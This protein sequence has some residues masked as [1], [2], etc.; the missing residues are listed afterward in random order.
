MKILLIGGTG[1][2]SSSVTR[3]AIDNGMDVTLLNRGNRPCPEGAHS[4]IADMNDE[5]T[6]KQ[7]LSGQHFDVVANFIVFTPEQAQRDIRLFSGITDK[8]IF[9]SS[10][11]AYQK[12]PLSPFITEDTPLENP[13]WEYSRNKAACEQ[14]YLN[15]Y[16]KNGFPAVI[17]RPSHT[18]CEKNV[19]VAIHGKGGSYTVLKRMLDGKKVIVHGDGSSLWTLTHSRDFAK[20][21]VGLME[22]PNVLGQAFHITSD[23]SLCWNRIYQIVADCLGVEYRPCHITSDDLCK[24]DPEYI[25]TLLGDKANSVIF[26]NTKIKSVAPEFKDFL[27]FAQGA[28]QAV[29]YMLSHPEC[30]FVD[31]EFNA[32]CDQMIALS[33]KN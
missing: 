6:V 5:N 21:F 26:D 24:V 11:S 31:E 10:A 20:G 27:P 16:D 23:E 12:P 30:Q 29:D 25:G 19:P 4:L 33:E 13:F 15:E 9:I 18:Y 17:V 22:A 32:F 2:I 14:I 8:Y 28:K 3:R 1:T 7:A